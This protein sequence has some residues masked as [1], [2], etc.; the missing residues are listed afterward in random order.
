MGV[1]T[2]RL[3]AT[4]LTTAAATT[5]FTT[6]SGETGIVKTLTVQNVTAGAVTLTW[7]LTIGGVNYGFLVQQLAA[8]AMTNV[9]VYLV[10]QPGESLGAI[11]SSANAL[12]VTA[13]GTELEGVAD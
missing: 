3:A 7:F 12:R 10:L 13:H 4:T 9:S 6:S 11:A 2:K 8:N 1:R 5:L